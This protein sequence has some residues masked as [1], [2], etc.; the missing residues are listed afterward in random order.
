MA[1]LKLPTNIFRL[2]NYDSHFL[3]T[4]ISQFP[5]AF[6]LNSSEQNSW[7]KWYTFHTGGAK[8]KPMFHII[9]GALNDPIFSF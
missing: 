6:L 1:F 2:L 5:L 8:A 3:V 4:R 9:S 7:D